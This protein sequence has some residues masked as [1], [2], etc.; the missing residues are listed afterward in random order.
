M[1]LFMNSLPRI[2]GKTHMSVRWTCLPNLN[3]VAHKSCR[4]RKGLSRLFLAR[5]LAIQNALWEAVKW[6]LSS[7]YGDF[8]SSPRSQHMSHCLNS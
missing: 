4:R 6:S 7:S 8:L 1:L 2:K 5:L 3:T